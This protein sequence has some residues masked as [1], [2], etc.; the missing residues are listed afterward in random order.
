MSVTI[1]SVGK[2]WKSTPYPLTNVYTNV[3]ARGVDIFILQSLLFIVDG[4]LI[5]LEEI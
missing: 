5:I 1:Q 2:A 4:H 3:F